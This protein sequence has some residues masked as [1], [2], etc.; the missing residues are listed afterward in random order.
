MTRQGEVEIREKLGIPAEAEQVLIFAESSH[1]DP[2]WLHTSE[3]YFQRFVE[4]NLDRA[5]AALQAEPRR[6]YSLECVF[7]LQMY[8]QRRPAMH[9]LIRNLF[10][11]GR[12]RLTS[13]GVTT[14]DTLLPSSEAILRDLL[15]G[16]EWLRGNELKCEPRLAYFTDSFGCSPALP[17]L[18][19]AAG[20]DRTALTRIDGMYFR[21]AEYEYARN[22]PRPGSSAARLLQDE[23]S[24]DFT[25]LDMNGA[26]V[27]C[28][29]NA[30]TYGHGDMLAYRGLSRTY[31]FR[32]ALLD[33]SEANIARRIHQYRKELAPYSRTPYL[34]CPIG[35]DFVEPIPDLV[36]LLDRYNARRYP[37]TGLWVLNAGLDDYLDLVEC[38]Q[39]VLPVIELDPNPYWTGFY[40]S[41]PNLKR[42]CHELVERLRLA[43]WLACSLGSTPAMNVAGDLEAPWWRAV[44][45]NHHDYITGTSPDGTVYQEQIP[46]L[47]AAL[48]RTGEILRRMEKERV[49]SLDV[50]LVDPSETGVL[51]ERRE[52]LASDPVVAGVR[53]T[54][55]SNQDDSSTAAGRT[56]NL[57]RQGSLLK[58]EMGDYY[59]ELNEALGGCVTSLQEER[60]SSGEGGTTGLQR[61]QVPSNDL[62]SYADS[63]GLWRMG[64]EFRGG[65]LREVWRASCERSG[66]EVDE[67][68][69]AIQV[70]SQIELDGERIMRS[71]WIA[72]GTPLIFGRVEGRAPEGRTVTLAF[73][74]GI[75]TEWLAMAQPGGVVTRPVEKIYQ[76]TFWPVQGFVHICDRESGTG[77]AVFVAVPT[78]VTYRQGG[79]L[80]LVALRNAT[81]EVAWGFLP[82]LG[83]PASGFER[84]TFQFDYALMFTDGGDWRANQLER[85]A[86]EFAR[87]ILAGEVGGRLWQVAVSMLEIKY[88]DQAASPIQVHA[89]K[90][91]SNG[92]GIV[93]RL[94]SLAP[95]AGMIRVRVRLGRILAAVLCDAR[96]R[97]LEPLQVQDGWVQFRMVDAITSVRLI[98]ENTQP[99]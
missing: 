36:G 87:S 21:G 24:L 64:H 60:D 39:G 53:A 41:R 94:G 4:S 80:E 7:F 77:M 27:L 82:L 61:L 9:D 89:L 52:D 37:D 67:R 26:R 98:I 91:A 72:E 78:G 92:D 54:F 11:G 55:D 44:V 51:F 57:A 6:V 73:E 28:H 8:W 17:S 40:A 49:D 38:Y 84:E 56:S 86:H 68:A 3:A 20:F 75:A 19:K 5:L 81:R 43:E 32:T 65:R 15:I 50:E 2:D 46:W 42:R 47:D 70:R 76:P 13:S 18:L 69:N 23:K 33:R 74:T 62:I 66:L 30:F 88:T 35:F 58:L 31:V 34:F 59:I 90:P 97:N 25:W 22:F 45:S 71:L 93:L 14:A 99:T 29:W 12:L 95:P 63:G 48:T 79:C 96:E 85:I 10:A 16:Q 83:N 1:W